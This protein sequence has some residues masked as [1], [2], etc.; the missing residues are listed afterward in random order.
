MNSSTRYSP[1][2][3]DR[4]VR[5]VLE[6]QGEHD[7]Q[8]SAVTSVASKLGCTAET[9]RKWV[10]QVERDRGV[11]AGL[12]SEE[13]RRLKEL[14]HENREMRRANELLRK[15]FGVFVYF[16]QTTPPPFAQAEHERR[17]R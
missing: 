5:L 11:R 9:L 7:S 14:E 10:R 13:R 3:R 4:A 8:W 15:A 2:V 1:E 6:H 16:R 12:T 17:A